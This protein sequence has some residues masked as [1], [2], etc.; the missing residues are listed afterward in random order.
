MRNAVSERNLL[1]RL[2]DQLLQPKIDEQLLQDAI[3]R[4]R[5]QQ[6]VPVLWLLGKTQSGKTS[7][8]RTLTG[9]P[10]ADIGNGF[11]PC[12]RTARF[13]DFPADVPV[14]LSGYARPG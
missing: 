12:T 3:S 5:Q 4:A 9:S 8:I 13:Y 11:R 1:T 6:P 2:K 7:L 14:A 10:D